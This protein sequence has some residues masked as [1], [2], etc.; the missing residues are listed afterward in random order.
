M[1]IFWRLVL[2]HLI[3]D[4]T[5][6]TNQIASWK[7]S[8]VWGM[9]VHCGI[10]PLLYVIFLWKYLGQVWLHIG[11]VP[12]TGTLCVILIFVFHF[13]EDEWRVWSVEKRGAPDNSFFYVWD[14]VIHYAVLFAMSPVLDG[15]TSKF[16]LISYPSIMGVVPHT[17]ALGMSVL[18]RFLTIT[19]PE[20][21]VF[22]GIL[23]VIVTHFTTVTIYFFEKDFFGGE[24]PAT[25]EKYISMAERL[26]VTGCFLL[27]GLW[28]IG[29]IVV[30]LGWVVVSKIRRVYDFSWTNIIIG[31]VTAIFCGFFIRNLIYS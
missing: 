27:P 9:L 4:F 20:N 14:Q 11:P 31:N 28:W 8:S 21:W 19:R 10:H 24:Y 5:L 18:E 2:G 29:L 30:W 26:V 25:D 22:I 16:G 15:A 6:Q 17:Q 3:G 1:E 23:F 12:L 13:I 7:R